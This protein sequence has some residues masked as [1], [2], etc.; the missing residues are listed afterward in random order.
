MWARRFLQEADVMLSLSQSFRV[1]YPQI[2][3][4]YVQFV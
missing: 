1:I 3:I 2:A 4:I